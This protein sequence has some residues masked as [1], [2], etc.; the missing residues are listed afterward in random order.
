MLA[1]DP[2]SDLSDR[3]THQEESGSHNP[4][5]DGLGRGGRGARERAWIG[6]SGVG[7]PPIIPPKFGGVEA[8]RGQKHEQEGVVHGWFA[9]LLVGHLRFHS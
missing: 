7:R 9:R 4:D 2:K 5:G 6:P 3:F 1:V 8:S